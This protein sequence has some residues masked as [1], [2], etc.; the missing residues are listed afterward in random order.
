VSGYEVVAQATDAGTLRPPRPRAH[1]RTGIWLKEILADTGYA[2]ALDPVDWARAGVELDA[3]YQETD[4]T[5]RR[6][7]RAPRRRI[8]QSAFTWRAEEQVDVCPR[9]HQLT[10]IS[11]EARGR[12]EGRPVE[13]T[14]Y[15]CPKEHCQACPLAPRCTSGAKGRTI[16]R[17]EH[18][19]LIEAHRAKMETPEAEAI[20]RKRCRTVELRFADT[21]QH[22]GS[23]RLSGR[24]LER[25]R[26]EVGLC[27]LAH[28]LVAV[29]AASRRKAAEAP[30]ETP[31]ENAA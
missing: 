4:W 6:R 1:D 8:P 31:C 18:E 16:K 3:P 11:R 22:R 12:A 2:S 20:Y 24:G 29:R 28:N 13:L 15:R 26:I 10:R 7:A 14:T 17:D 9:G 27:V 21:Q 19:E 23:R 25:A 30:D 5:E